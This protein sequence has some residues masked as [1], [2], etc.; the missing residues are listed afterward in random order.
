VRG[1][2]RSLAIT[3]V[4]DTGG[5][6]CSLRR[7]GRVVNRKRVQRLWREEGLRVP[8]RHASAAGATAATRT[9]HVDVPCVPGRYGRSTSSSTRP[10]TGGSSK[11]LNIVDEFTRQALVTHVARSCDADGVLTVLDRLQAEHGAPGFLR[12][13]NGP[14]M[15]ATALKDWCRFNTAGTIYI[16]P[17]SPWQNPYVE[18]FNSRMRDEHW[19]VEEFTTLT[20]AQ[21]LTEQW[22]IEYNTIRPHSALAGH[23]PDEYAE[24]W[25]TENKQPTPTLS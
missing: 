11:S 24:R 13:D 3:P 17:G 2:E 19:N 8:R 22:R 15:I 6:P 20:E 9:V 23:P 18:S 1:C 4:G 25:R 5:R 21:I 7:E 14:E 16:D 10:T 12:M